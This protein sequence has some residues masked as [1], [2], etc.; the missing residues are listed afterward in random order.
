[1]KPFGLWEC[2]VLVSFWVA[3]LTAFLVG[4]L[5]MLGH[6]VQVFLVL[7]LGWVACQLY[8]EYAATLRCE[9]GR[10]RAFADWAKRQNRLKGI[11]S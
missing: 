9:Y 1:M 3:G 5:V 7:G 11:D 8:R 6:V 4:G 10:R 2:L